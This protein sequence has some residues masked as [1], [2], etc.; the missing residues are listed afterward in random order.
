MDGSDNIETRT[1]N[2]AEAKRK[3]QKKNLDIV[4]PVRI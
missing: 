4:F 1:T 3:A 2:D